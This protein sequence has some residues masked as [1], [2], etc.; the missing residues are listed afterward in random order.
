[1]R[2][3]KSAI[4]NGQAT[5]YRSA[6][7]GDPF[8]DPSEYSYSQ[9]EWSYKHY[10]GPQGL[11]PNVT[12][13][14]TLE[15]SELAARRL[16]GVSAL[17]LDAEWKSGD[18]LEVGENIS[19]IQVASESEIVLIHI[20]MFP[21]SEAHDQST[22]DMLIG[23]VLK[24][25]LEA[26][27][28]VKVG[29]SIAGDGHRLRKYLNIQCLGLL[30]LT[31]FAKVLDP[32]TIRPQSL[33]SLVLTHLG[34]PLDK[35]VRQS[36]WELPISPKLKEYA[37]SDVYA[38]LVLF[39]CM[40]SKPLLMQPVPAP[41]VFVVMK[42]DVDDGSS[43]FQTRISDFLPSSQGGPTSLD[44]STSAGKGKK[45]KRE[46]TSDQVLETKLFQER[47][48][49]APRG[50]F[51]G[52]VASNKVLERLAK[53]KPLTWPA[54]LATE[55]VAKQIK[56]HRIAFRSFL[57][58]IQDHVM[59][60]EEEGTIYDTQLSSQPIPS[61]SMPSSS[62]NSTMS[63]TPALSSSQ[64]RQTAQAARSSPKQSATTKPKGN[65]KKAR[66][67][68][69]MRAIEP[70]YATW[71]KAIDDKL[72]EDDLHIYDDDSALR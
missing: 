57:E 45:R 9:G 72:D 26:P 60:Q 29:A 32:K 39:Q 30:D 65:E 21:G 46:P 50:V 64:P 34:L 22:V 63:S 47:L 42:V 28:V 24:S 27:L 6:S 33:S 56:R 10:K 58:T 69:K 44:A 35:S 18:G 13:C 23:P 5:D 25:I 54:L 31:Q 38:G 71:L 11:P 4:V 7:G 12:Y 8:Q 17:G 16:I 51:I 66:K 15:K 41:P 68:S 49:N 43:N 40:N 55:G 48:K 52:E 53:E 20:A 3:L 61:S 2:N 37:A 19:M 1:M 14:N 59:Q 70:D 36:H 67:E 62:S